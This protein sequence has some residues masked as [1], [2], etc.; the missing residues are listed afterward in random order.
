MRNSQR[1]TRRWVREQVRRTRAMLASLPTVC[2]WAGRLERAAA[3]ERR[4][5]PIPSAPGYLWTEVPAGQDRPRLVYG[6]S[7]ERAACVLVEPT[8]SVVVR[9]PVVAPTGVYVAIGVARQGED[10]QR[11]RIHHLRRAP[12]AAALPDIV[13]DAALVPVVWT[14]CGTSFYYSAYAWNAVARR[15]A[16]TVVKCHRLGERGT[17]DRVVYHST[18]G[19][20]LC[21]PVA[22]TEDE[23]VIAETRGA[24][25]ATTLRGLRRSDGAI[26][27]TWDAQAR[28]FSAI[29]R[30]D[31]RLLWI[32]TDKNASRR[33]VL[34]CEVTRRGCKTVKTVVPESDALIYLARYVDG[35]IWLVKKA[36]QGDTVARVSLDGA[37]LREH[38]LPSGT[39]VDEVQSS[40]SD[41]T[42]WV[43]CSGFNRP[44]YV[45]AFSRRK[46][47]QIWSAGRRRTCRVRTEAYKA[48]KGGRLFLSLVSPHGVA[49]RERRPTLMSVY[50]GFGV[51][52]STS[53]SAAVDAWVEAG[54]RFASVGVRGGGDGGSDQHQAGAGGNRGKGVQDF[55]DAARFLI[56]HGR[57]LPGQLGVMAHSNGA[58]IAASSVLANPELFSV[59]LLS[60]GV[61]DLSDDWVSGALWPWAGEFAS[62]NRRSPRCDKRSTSPSDLVSAA[63]TAPA[64]LVT[65]G[66][67]DQRVPPTQSLEFVARL[68]RAGCEAAFLRVID[69][70]GHA[71]ADSVRAQIREISEELA[72]AEDRLMS[73]WSER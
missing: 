48:Y 53:F 68:Q 42:L 61:F 10:S 16:P 46:T 9:M 30:R 59:A 38:R 3:G 8:K 62:R 18:R 24:L 28:W 12:P 50:G 44:P 60:G 27:W 6:E 37:L 67:R 69:D 47:R 43:R 71:A 20:M 70:R 19:D 17:E 34:L 13:H 55:C 26:T 32:L 45:K 73:M 22:V 65:C 39:S 49:E 54:Y 15:T 35:E 5:A 66:A 64:V 29:I 23:L 1:T 4:S 72:F 31:E 2:D 11:W 21:R 56:R 51:P 52:R 14:R 25:N 7:P 36:E 57:A 63:K 41:D 33:Q 58:A 40:G